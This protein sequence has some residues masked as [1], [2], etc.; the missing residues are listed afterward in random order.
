MALDWNFSRRWA[1]VALG[2]GIMV[3][4][5]SS[6]LTRYAQ[7]DGVSSLSIAAVRL[8]LASILLTPFAL[9][10]RSGELRALTK[11]DLLLAIGA[12]LLLAAHFA[13][14]ISSLAYT[15]VAN[16]TAL[17]TTNPI[18]IAAVSM[19]LFHER[20]RLELAAAIGFAL[21]GSIL[22]FIA[23]GG[24]DLAQAN[25]RLGNTLA[26]LGSFTVSGYLLIGR[27]LRRRL[28]LL[29]YIWLVYSVAAIALAVLALIAREPLW[30]FSPSAWLFMLALALGPQLMGHS[31]FNWALKRVSATL[32][33][34]AI[35]GE[36]IGSA[37]LALLL[38]DEGFSSLQIAGFV[39]LLIA[40]YL[41]A[42]SEQR[43]N[44]APVYR[45]E[46]QVSANK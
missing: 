36:P 6:I 46:S 44:Q 31:A 1:Y 20:M 22:I 37:M 32:I 35:L 41:G 28:S 16:S 29:A 19:V 11:R 33:A 27:A 17:V 25:P 2:L 30:G 13:T 23:E 42:R 43:S 3:I 4:S 21:C 24:A 7:A 10:S 8:L 5:S 38:F 9:A 12:G 15:S 39:L 45:P 34:L 18:W 14:W 26:L 40:I